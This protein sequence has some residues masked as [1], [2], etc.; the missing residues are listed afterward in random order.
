MPPMIL[1]TRNPHKLVEV[2]R[3]LG[4]DSVLALPDDVELG[5]ELGE[6]FTENALAK[7]REAAAATARVAIADDS[8]ICAAALDGAPGV[9]SARFAGERAGDEQN[10]ALLIECVPPGSGLAYVCSIAYVDPAPDGVEHVFEG[11]CEGRMAAAALGDGGFG[12]DPVFIP[13]AGDG[14]TMAQLDPPEK[15]ALSHRGIALRA[16]A[17]WLAK[18]RSR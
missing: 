7:A 2:R 3:L 8:G 5:P 12:Y 15:D 17:A 1:A 4:D 14:R 11:R 10:L 16:L 18:Q 9:R 13:E 6:T